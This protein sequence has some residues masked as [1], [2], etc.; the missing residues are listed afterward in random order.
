VKTFYPEIIKQNAKFLNISP[1]VYIGK[2][3]SKE[4][5]N[6]NV[7]LDLIQTF[8]L[9]KR[10]FIEQLDEKIKKI[11]DMD[12]NSIEMLSTMQAYPY[13]PEDMAEELAVIKNIII[14]MECR[15]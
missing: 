8:E 4:L 3:Q 12:G 14:E 11:I 2:L 10:K 13:I 1:I 6:E 15:T 7:D 9:E 5:A